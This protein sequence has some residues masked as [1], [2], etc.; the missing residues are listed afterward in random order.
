MNNKIVK[1]DLLRYIEYSKENNYMYIAVQTKLKHFNEPQ[2]IIHRYKD[3]DNVYDYYNTRYSDYEILSFI[4]ISDN[5]ELKNIDIL[6]L[7]VYRILYG[8]DLCSDSY[9]ISIEIKDNGETY[10]R[11][12]SNKTTLGEVKL[13]MKSLSNRNDNCIVNLNQYE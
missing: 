4:G 8:Y 7:D 11:Q 1:E 13:L 12:L 2:I 10:Y 9:Y 3:F 5:F 6:N